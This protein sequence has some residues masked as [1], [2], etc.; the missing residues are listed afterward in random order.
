[1]P[2]GDWTTA[3]DDLLVGRL[4]TCTLCGRRGGAHWTDIAELP[5]LTVAFRLCAS[6]R[7]RDPQRARLAALLVQRYGAP[8]HE[9][10]I[11][12]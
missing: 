5:A 10:G 11:P 1:M 7:D 6:C 8:P 4:R 2:H 9:S 12:S 3:F